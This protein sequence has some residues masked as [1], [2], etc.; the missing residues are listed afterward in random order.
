MNTILSL[1]VKG[2]D[3]SFHEPYASLMKGLVYGLPIQIDP[4]LKQEIVKSGLAHLVVLSGAN[5]TLLTQFSEK[6]FFSLSKKLGIL[7]QLI[8]LC[9]FVLLVGPQAPLMRAVS[10]FI[11]TIVCVLAGRPS[12]IVWN[13]FLTIFFVAILQPKWITSISFQLSVFATIGIII[14]GIVSPY[15]EKKLNPFSE[16]FFESWVVF[17]VTAP[18]SIWYFKSIS[19]MSPVSTALVSWLIVP[20]MIAGFAISLLYSIFPPLA[21][22]IALPTQMGLHFIIFIIQMTGRLPFGYILF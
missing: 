3:A 8:F 21:P 18:V 9:G 19:I 15:F 10:M 1:A 5:V 6:L 17:L 14:W 11:C 4:V 12:S 22:L 16:V 7:F 13:L 2:I 20:L